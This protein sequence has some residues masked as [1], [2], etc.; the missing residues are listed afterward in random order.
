[1]KKK[2][3]ILAS[4]IAASF[5]LFIGILL[6]AFVGVLYEDN[7]MAINF[8]EKI[9]VI[10]V[11]GVIS[12]SANVIRQLK[13]FGDDSSIPALVIHIDS[14]GGGV[15]ASQEIYEEIRKVRE[16]GKT[17]VASMGSLGASGGYY[18][19]CAADTIV[20][21]PGTITGSIG[22]IFE[23]PIIEELLKKMGIRFEVIKSG[24]MKDVGSFARSI[25][26]KE[27]E[28]LQQVIDDT[29]DQFV[30]VVVKE[31]ELSQSQVYKLADGRVFTGRQAQKLK[32]IDELGDLEDAIEIAAKMAGIKGKPRTVKERVR[33]V[34][35]WDVL[36][37]SLNK[38]DELSKAENFTPKLQYL[39]KIK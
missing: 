10:D 1:M 4:I 9:A 39:Y 33:R 31:R 11:H 14:P 28:Y 24:E 25:T 7:N 20:A 19:A 8:G 3:I 12:S 32:L 35:F 30:D 5:I 16:K 18:I 38:V 36:S 13:K 29:Y 22:V 27:R 2:D 34:T 6:L 37:E 21:N 15:A 26:P 23:V 17:V